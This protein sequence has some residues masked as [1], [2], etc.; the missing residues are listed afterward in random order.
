MGELADIA[1]VQSQ[2]MWDAYDEVDRHR[3][4]QG[5]E[6]QNEVAA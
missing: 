1:R 6:I 3:R 4:E 2:R 5:I